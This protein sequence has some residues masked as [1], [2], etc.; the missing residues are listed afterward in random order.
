[1]RVKAVVCLFA[2]LSF[3]LM[4]GCG[5]G[6]SS[7]QGPSNPSNP[8][9]QSIAI[10]SSETSV[11]V[12]ATQQLTATGTYSDGTSKNITSTVAWSSSSSS[13]AAVKA[14]LVTGVKGGSVT[15]TATLSNISKGTTLTVTPVQVSIGV[16]SSNNNYSANIGSTLQM[17]A[18]A[19]FNDGSTSAITSKAAWSSSSTKIATVNSAGLVDA[20]SAGTAT[21]TAAYNGQTGFALITV[22]SSSTSG[23]PTLKSIAVTPNPATA[24]LGSPLTL[25]ATGSY[26]DGSSKNISSSVTWSSSATSTAVAG[27]DGVVTPVAVGQSTI[28]ATSGSVSG[29]TVLT[30]TNSLT[31]ISISASG[32]SV[33]VAS[34]LQL[35]ALGTYQNGKSPIPLSNVT[36]TS[37]ASTLA[38]VSNSGL[39]SGVKGGSVTI[40]AKFESF[41]SSINVTVV[42]VLQSMILSPAGPAILLGGQQQFTATGSYNDGS[43]QDL[44]QKS[45]WSTSDSALATASPSGLAEGIAPGPITI[46]ASYGSITA[47][48]ALNIVR[49]IYATFTGSYA[50]TLT[51]SDTRGP[52]F[53]AGALTPDGKGNISGVEDCNTASGVQKDIPLS[54]TYVIYPDGRG[55]ILFNSNAC[56]SAGVTWRVI[57]TAGGA[58]GALVEFDGLGYAKGSLTQQTTAALS[59]ASVKGTYVFRLGGFDGSGTQGVGVVGE[60]AANGAGTISS[61]LEDVNNASTISAAVAIDA[62][63]YSVGSNGRGTL[64]LKTA[65]ATT[66]YVL[67]LVDSTKFYL[68]QIDAAA[69]S[70]TALTG[71]AELQSAQTYDAATLNGNYSFLVERPVIAAAGQVLSQNEF[72]EIG[73]LAFDGVGTVS[74]NRNHVGISGSFTVSTNGVNGRGSLNTCPSTGTCDDQRLYS[75]YLVSPSK[76]FVLETYTYPN[77]ESSNPVTGEADLQTGTPYSDATLVGTYAVQ[78]AEPIA[79]YAQS[80]LWLTFDGTGNIVGI[81]D[82]SISGQVSSS[83]VGNA[84]YLYPANL[85]GA[86]EIELTTAQ[87]T[88]DFVL[89]LVSPQSAWIHALNPDLDG[90][91]DQ[92]SQ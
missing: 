43:T 20:V 10:T 41:S 26:S 91:L 30:V 18:T 72:A 32:D 54:G 3:S 53:F 14:G 68:L 66:N 88:Q 39:V 25:T 78:S 50:F 19:N 86:E 22:N 85:A 81:S 37:S 49:K 83:V 31:A 71:M 4:V 12:G 80:L 61:G 45:K 52:S 74:G 56:H 70:S 62:S 48:T 69:V 6:S 67:Y 28:K 89:Y 34:T 51:S 92:Q 15:I 63:T 1:M 75:I 33:N 58:S 57:L 13:I 2:V 17:V 42:P 16:S 47:T 38:T 24:I 64:Q 60:V 35:T 8:S 84:F 87:G 77:W 23:A 82:A 21:I 59:A 90:S 46:S 79:V 40:S 44:T 36:W 5:S 7:S 76:M 27:S 11:L 73:N 55:N 29:S 9:L 65:S